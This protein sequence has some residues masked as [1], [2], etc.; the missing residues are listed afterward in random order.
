M[1]K[2]LKFA[3][4]PSG[5]VVYRDTGNLYRGKHTIKAGRNGIITVYGKDGRKIGTVGKPNKTQSARIAKKDK[6]RQK[7]R[8][9]Q[10][11]RSIYQMNDVDEIAQEYGS[12]VPDNGWRSTAIAKRAWYEVDK[13]DRPEFLTIN[14]REIM[15][16]A[17][18]LKQA[19][20][21]GV[22]TVEE[23]NERYQAFMDGTKEERSGLW[24][25]IDDLSSERGWKPSSPPVEN[26]GGYWSV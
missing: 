8:E 5:Q 12:S 14:Q 3:L 24:D 11:R 4:S 2:Y 20:D 23:A 25:E 18:I 22:M 19:V 1:A 7:R 10:L 26:Y 15:N 21:S 6:A 13:K 17:S 9:R 16:Y